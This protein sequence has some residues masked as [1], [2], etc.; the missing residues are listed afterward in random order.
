MEGFDGI[1]L[2]TAE[3][4]NG[5]M[6]TAMSVAENLL[7]AYPELSAIFCCDDPMGSGAGQA[8][9]ASGK[10][11]V[12]CGFDGSPDGAQAI[13]DGVMDLTIAQTPR[14]MGLKAVEHAIQYLNGEEVE[15]VIY[16]DC[17]VV[18][19]SNAADYLEWH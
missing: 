15:R 19:A 13:I 8:V 10:D 7:T 12:V 1:E 5:D 17:E 4:G 2:V 16:T 6:G 3:Y 11:V 14:I 9:A 18:D